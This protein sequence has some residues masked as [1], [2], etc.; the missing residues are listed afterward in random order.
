MD[1]RKSLWPYNIHTTS[2][3]NTSAQL[4]TQTKESAD[5][6]SVRHASGRQVDAPIGLQNCRDVDMQHSTAYAKNNP[7]TLA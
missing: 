1:V 7:T 4:G 6:V 5:S 3:E 2:T